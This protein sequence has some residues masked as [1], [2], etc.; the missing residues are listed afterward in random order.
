M[1]LGAAFAIRAQEVV[2]ALESPS[3]GGHRALIDWDRERRSMSMP[4]YRAPNVRRG[5]LRSESA[6]LFRSYAENTSIDWARR[7]ASDLAA[8]AGA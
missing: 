5:L 3:D 8:Q 7:W 4:G 6:A 2:Y 1:C